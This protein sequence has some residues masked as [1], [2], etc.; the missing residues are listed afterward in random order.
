MPTTFLYDDPQG[1]FI[2]VI[3]ARLQRIKEEHQIHLKTAG[4]MDARMD[5]AEEEAAAA[6]RQQA[7]EE[8]Q[9]KGEPRL[10]QLPLKQL[11]R[12]RA[13]E[14]GALFGPLPRDEPPWSDVLPA[15]PRV[16]AETLLVFF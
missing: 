2:T 5:E 13:P 9:R 14:R 7:Q 8:R 10:Q 12:F 16:A 3:E 4:N 11:L 6:L 1:Y 15:P